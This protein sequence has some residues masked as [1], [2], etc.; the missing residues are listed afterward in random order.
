MVMVLREAQ[1]GKLETKLVRQELRDA[2]TVG[3][4]SSWV[5]TQQE[6]IAA[7]DPV[8]QGLS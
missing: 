3:T 1:M 5:R 4:V 7:V 6:R 8:R 2:R